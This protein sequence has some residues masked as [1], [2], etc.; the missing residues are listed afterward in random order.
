MFPNKY[1]STKVKIS[2]PLEEEGEK[3]GIERERR[4]VTKDLLQFLFFS[5]LL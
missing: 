1:L 4:K 5:K 2:L 3:G